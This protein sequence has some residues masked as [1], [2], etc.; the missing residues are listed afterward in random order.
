VRVLSTRRFIRALALAA[1]ASAFTA[2]PALAA[3]SWSLSLSNT[4]TVLPRTDQRMEYLAQITNN[5]NE[6]TAGPLSFEFELPGG[7]DTGVF[8]ASGMNWTCVNVPAAGAAHARL[9][10]ERTAPFKVGTQVITIVV[11]L[12]E[13][14][15]DPGIATATIS[16]GGAPALASDSA[17][18]EF[19]P[20]PG[21][22]FGILANS[23]VAGVF[24]EDGSQST[25]AGSHPFKAFTTFGFNVFHD[26]N[27]DIG[28]TDN[29]RDTVV[30]AAR[31]FVGNALAAPELCASVEEVILGTCPDKSAVGGSDIF[32]NAGIGIHEDYYPNN[33]SFA[34]TVP[35]YSIE[36]EFGQPAEFSF[37]PAR[38]PYSFV[39]ELRADEGYAI[40]FRTAPILANP[41]LFGV[42][43]DLCNFGA[44]LQPAVKFGEFVVEGAKYL[45]C[46][47]SND[48]EANPVPL[49]TNPTRCAGAPPANGL[50]VDSWQHP[51]EVKTAEDIAAAVTGCDAVKFEPDSSLVPV[52]HQADT[53]TGLN[54]EIKMP[55]EGVLT[56]TGV[57][58]ANLDTVTVTFPKGMS[59][60][61]AAADGLQGC[62]PAQ[63]KLGSNAKDECPESSKVGTVE[64]DTPL[65]RKTLTGS[66]F[67]AQQNHNP[68]QAPIGLYMDFDSP[69]DGVR[70]KVAGKLVADPVTGQLTSVFTE[71]PE[72]PFSRLALKFHGGPRAALVNPPKC[73][74]YA[75]HSEFSP[76]SAVNP[77]NPTPDEI[78]SQDSTYEVSSGPNGSPCPDG[79]LAAKMNSGLES[80]KAGAKSPFDFTL[81]REDASQRFSGVSVT[82][83]KGLTAYPKGI[84]YC[85]DATLAGISEAEETGRAELEHPAC[86]AASQVGTVQAGAGSGPFPFQAPGRVYLA[87]PYKN[88]P[89]SLAVVTPAVAGPFDLGSVVIRNALHVDP[90]TTQVTTKSDPIP[91]ILHGVLLDL[92]QIRLSLNRPGFT[93]APTNCEPMSVNATVSGEG[94]ASASLSNRFQVGDC[95]ALGFKPKLTMKLF[96]GTHRGSH[97]RLVATLTERGGDANVAGASVALPHSEFLDQAHIRTVCTRVQFAAHQ[98]PAAS[99]YG[100]AEA[101]TPLTDYAVKGPVYLRSSDNPLPDLVA[102]LRGPDSQPI[103]V[104]LDG[105]IDSV[106]GGIRSSFEAV[107]DQPVSSFVLRMQGG[108]KGLLV[109]S[110]DI[111]KSTNRVSANFTAQNGRVAALR[112]VLQNSCKKAPKKHKRHKRHSGR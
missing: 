83:P 28:P 104:V 14:S 75:I 15:E 60:N 48:P 103:E 25:A 20:G 107:P 96:G 32:T 81:T 72:A 82:T 52:N 58:Q 92:R 65:I 53:P 16:G 80:P 24:N 42:N 10:C 51:D 40:S 21:F 8:S 99:I 93:A 33:L 54:V 6:A 9:N 71:N 5:G 69:R 110:R 88:A 23:F 30:D 19:E 45:G 50:R 13:S 100:E 97:P 61:P 39:P 56:N 7:P 2:A 76:W 68:F 22:P 98:C 63:I 46:K 70:I 31:G 106:N 87:G 11:Q 34:F 27:G 95:A 41:A 89:V 101:I 84:P 90:E 43:V 73:G 91:T 78:V 17:T 105:R 79:V 57:S 86:P 102:T 67:V 38:T 64:I 111:C 37:A 12:S 35:I 26:T 74:T 59:I 77:A 66:V 47:Q 62:S 29:V 55:I 109:N 18:Y 1:V 44:K 94:G 36:P 112:P 49:A 85:S 4:P 108:N 3:P